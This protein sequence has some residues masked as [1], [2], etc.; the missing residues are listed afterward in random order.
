MK[1]KLLY[2]DCFCGISGDMH[3]GALLDLGVDSGYL[4]RELSG[5]RMNGEFELAVKRTQK[6][7]ITG[8][9]ADVILKNQDPEHHVHRHLQEIRA[10]I[11]GSELSGTV[12]KLSMRMFTKIAE[13]EGKVHGLPPEEVHFHEVGAVDSIVDLVGAAILLDALKPDRILSSPVQVGGGYVRCAHGLIPVPAPATVEIL[14]GV[15]I[16]SGLVPFETAT[17]TGAAILACNADAFTERMDFT[18]QKIGYGFGTRE[19]EVPNALRV[20]SGEASDEGEGEQILL[21]T[22][23]DDMNPEFYS[24][25]EEKLFR[26]GA[27]DVFKT[28]IVMKKGRPAVKLSVLTGAAEEEKMTEI[29][30]HETTSLGLR[31]FRVG[32]VMMEREFSSLPTKYGTISV[33]KAYDQGKQ[34]KY[35]AEYEDCKKAAET[36]QVPLAQ[37]YREVTRLMEQENP[38]PNM[39][40]NKE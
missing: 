16:R 2:Y 29:I 30:F 23:I 15:P 24:Y 3:L 13:A 17:P 25:V 35:K 18:V 19:L 22:N 5:L 28:P 36:S 12:K 11:E 40:G 4:I 1:T 10:I 39:G 6:N 9:K 31:R 38:K 14:T 33:K 27:L 34:V 8:T 32:K 26:A 37:V 20:F 7:G 21:E